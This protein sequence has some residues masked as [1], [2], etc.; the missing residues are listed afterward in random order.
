MKKQ[1]VSIIIISA[2]ILSG[3]GEGGITV[4][5]DNA[6]INTSTETNNAQAIVD[7]DVNTDVDV[8]NDKSTNENSNSDKDQTIV[9]EDNEIYQQL[10]KEYDHLV[11]ENEK[12]NQEIDSLKEENSNLKQQ[13][14]NVRNIEYKNIGLSI[15]G[16]AIPINKTNSS[17]VIDNK[18]YYS[19][20]FIDSFINSDMEKSIQDETM[21]VGRIIKNKAL[22]VDQY[23]YGHSYAGVYNSITDSYGKLHT[24][25]IVFNSSKCYITYNLNREYSLFRF[26]LA[27][28]NNASDNG[29][30]TLTIKADGEVVYTSEDLTK[31]TEKI[32]VADISI[33]NCSLLTI[34]Y[35]AYASCDCIMSDMEI[36]NE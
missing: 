21:Y 5:G 3:C 27:V 14:S 24:N 26:S 22:L 35:N 2:I 36:Y 23:E 25:S 4:T 13:S 31:A 28:R 34:E 18:V 15:D 8:N 30:G 20:E 12:L 9:I 11:D 7:T 1:F 19:E 16:N 29:I 32:D 10:K 6:T 17:V 33:K